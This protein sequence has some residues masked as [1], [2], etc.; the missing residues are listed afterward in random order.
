MGVLPALG[1]GVSLSMIGSFSANRQPTNK[2]LL[3]GYI[4]EVG[5][6]V[7]RGLFDEGE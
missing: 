2:E 6:W 4:S 3:E 7:R 5:A 1:V